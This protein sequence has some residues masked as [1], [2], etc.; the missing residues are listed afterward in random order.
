VAAE[1]DPNFIAQSTLNSLKKIDRLILE[2]FTRRFNDEPNATTNT[3]SGYL[4]T[5]YTEN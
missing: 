5:A 1:R 2:E 3:S 4:S